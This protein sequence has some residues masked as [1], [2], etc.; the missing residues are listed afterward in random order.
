MKKN[1]PQPPCPECEKLASVSED[2]NKIGDF[3]SWLHSKGWVIA[4][5][6]HNER[7]YEE[8][9]AIRRFQGDTG[10][11]QLLAEYYKID[12][13]KVDKERKELLKWIQKARS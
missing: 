10:I 11:N 1:I 7:R 6:E 2:S 9:V 8:L 4:G 3:L 5:Y 13:D 12:L